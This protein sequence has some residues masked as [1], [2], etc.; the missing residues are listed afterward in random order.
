M[1]AAPLPRRLLLVTAA[2]GRM[3][4]DSLAGISASSVPGFLAAEL[5]GAAAGMALLRLLSPEIGT[6]SRK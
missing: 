4:S 2:F 3:F 6:A 5:G 1:S